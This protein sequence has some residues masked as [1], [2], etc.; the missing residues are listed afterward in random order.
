[1]KKTKGAERTRRRPTVIWVLTVM[2]ILRPC[3]WLLQQKCP[4]TE[5]LSLAATLGAL[6]LPLCHIVHV[7]SLTFTCTCLK[8]V[9]KRKRFLDFIFKHIAILALK[10][11][12]SFIPRKMTFP[13]TSSSIWVL[14]SY[15]SPMIVFVS[16]I[17]W[18]SSSSP[19]SYYFKPQET[20][21]KWLV[22]FI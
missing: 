18:S 16:F 4:A 11:E 3:L 12:L 14:V 5:R 9:W 2:A 17:N 1:M 13:D 19:S 7:C 15:P 6:C 20:I 10:L 21:S 8:L 22:P